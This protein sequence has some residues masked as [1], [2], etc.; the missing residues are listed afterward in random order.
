MQAILYKGA[1]NAMSTRPQGLGA[2]H[3]SVREKQET[4]RTSSLQRPCKQSTLAC[5]MSSAWFL[6]CKA[7]G[8][9]RNVGDS[10]ASL[11]SSCREVPG[12]RAAGL[13]SFFFSCPQ[14]S[15]RAFYLYSS[16]C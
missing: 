1:V 10:R 13:P 15:S 5:S 16:S 9:S 8:Q 4:A 6:H 7:L 14:G 3:R 11:L 12:K 2:S